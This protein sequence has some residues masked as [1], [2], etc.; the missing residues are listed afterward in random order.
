MEKYNI[1]IMEVNMKRFRFVAVLFL[2]MVSLCACTNSNNNDV[3]KDAEDVKDE[4][5]VTEVKS[6]FP[7]KTITLVVPFGPGGVS[8]QVAR[9]FERNAKQYMPNGQGLVVVNKGGGASVPG[10]TE[11]ANAKPDGYTIGL[12]LDGPLLIQ[13]HM[14][15]ATYTP[16]DFEP[17]IR[18]ATNPLIFAVHA[19][20]QFQT[21]QE[22]LDYVKANPDSFIYGTGGI[23]NT[24]WIAMQRMIDETDI[25]LKYTPFSSTSEVYTAML[26]KHIDGECANSQEMMNQSNSGSIR[27]LVN[28][29]TTKKD[30]FED[31]PTMKELGYDMSTEVLYGFVAPKGTPD[32]IIQILHDV[33]KETLED[34]ETVKVLED[35]GVCINYGDR[36]EF[37][38]TIDQKYEEFGEVLKELNN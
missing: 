23:G 32:E 22:W 11:I 15:N 7:K 8:D 28:L 34:P 12:M 10:A 30:F 25:K 21:F 33:F 38:K 29:G 31:V 4:N 5:N 26:G 9:V 24:P 35:M 37:K 6:D 20:S 14:G 27:M 17:I 13:P 16:D 1:K 19:D 36:E 18:I 2:I 3:P